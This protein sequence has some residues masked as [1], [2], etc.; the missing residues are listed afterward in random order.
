MNQN[1]QYELMAGAALDKIQKCAP[2]ALAE[3]MN[4]G[5]DGQQLTALS[6]G[7][8]FS[9]RW[10]DGE[11]QP[12]LNSWHALTILQYLAN[13]EGIEP[14]GRYIALSDFRQG[15]LARGISFDRG[16][17]RVLERLGTYDAATLR[18]GAVKLGGRELREKPDL[19]FL[20]SF[21]P[22]LPVK[23]HIW[24]ADEDFPATGKVL[25]DASAERDLQI[26]AAG[27]AAGILLEL[28]EKAAAELANSSTG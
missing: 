24:L 21:L 7:I 11:V 5:W 1:R 3:R 18:A 28:L 12:K 23:L 22:K 10:Q 6:L 26:E 17:D 13:G 16:N 9:I 15:G 25:F 2:S 19:T 4:F 8:P 20:F 14:T 27:T